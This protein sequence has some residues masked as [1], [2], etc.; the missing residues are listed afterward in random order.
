MQMSAS[1]R[2]TAK[3]VLAASALTGMAALASRSLA[4]DVP[5]GKA[6]LY[7]AF[8][9]GVLFVFLVGAVVIIATIA[10]FILKQG[11]TDPQWFWFNGEPRG[12][13][14]LREQSRL[15]SRGLHKDADTS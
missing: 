5:L 1:Q 12:L 7:S 14:Q 11:G 9:A 10:Q 15:Q 6:L 2:F 3:I 4:P 13:R 8:G